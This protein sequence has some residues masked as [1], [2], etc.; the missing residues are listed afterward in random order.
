VR[1]DPPRPTQVESI[2]HTR[3]EQ[4]H[5]VHERTVANRGFNPFGATINTKGMF[6]FTS[7]ILETPLSEW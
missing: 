3:E 7:K 1:D 5:T 2:E 6:P 4:S